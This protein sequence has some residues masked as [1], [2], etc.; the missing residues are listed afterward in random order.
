MPQLQIWDSSTIFVYAPIF[1]GINVIYLR[2]LYSPWSPRQFLSILIIFPLMLGTKHASETILIDKEI[3]LVYKFDESV[4]GL[5]FFIEN[6]APSENRSCFLTTSSDMLSPGICQRGLLHWVDIGSKMLNVTAPD[7]SIVESA[8]G[9]NPYSHLCAHAREFS[10][11]SF[12]RE[13]LKL[14]GDLKKDAL[15][16]IPF[17]FNAL[18]ASPW[19]ENDPEGTACGEAMER[20]ACDLYL[21]QCGRSCYKKTICRQDCLDIHKVCP[22]AFFNA[23]LASY[24]TGYTFMHLWAPSGLKEKVEPFTDLMRLMSNA[25][26]SSE[27][28][29]DQ[30]FEPTRTWE[31][32]GGT[33]D[34]CF[35]SETEP[36]YYLELSPIQSKYW[37]IPGIDA[38]AYADPSTHVRERVWPNTTVVPRGGDS[39]INAFP[40][41]RSPIWW[42][43]AADSVGAGLSSRQL[44]IL[45]QFF[46]F[47]FTSVEQHFN[48]FALQLFELREAKEIFLRVTNYYFVN[49]RIIMTLLAALIPYFISRR[50]SSAQDGVNENKE[51][52]DMKVNFNVNTYFVHFLCLCQCLIVTFM[53][54]TSAVLS[55]WRDLLSESQI[56]KNQTNSTVLVH[57]VWV[58][59]LLLYNQICSAII[60]RPAHLSKILD[61]A[62]SSAEDENSQ[63]Y[64]PEDEIKEE[65]IAVSYH[66]D[67]EVWWIT[68]QA[69][70]FYLRA[71][72]KA[73]TLLG[74][75]SLMLLPIY[76]YIRIDKLS[77]F[78]SIISWMM[79]LL[80][81]LALYWLLDSDAITFK[82]VKVENRFLI[83]SKIVIYP[84]IL[85]LVF[86]TNLLDKEVDKNRRKRN[87]IRFTIYTTLVHT[88]YTI[89][90]AH[91]VDP[92]HGKDLIGYK[93]EGTDRLPENR[94]PYTL[95]ITLLSFAA[96]IFRFGLLIDS[97]ILAIQKTRGRTYQ[98]IMQRPEQI[99][100]DDLSFWF[101]RT[102]PAKVVAVTADDE[103]SGSPDR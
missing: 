21:P 101:T 80:H 16:K 33:L 87:T 54:Y 36:S 59:S 60:L 65:E 1:I 35:D 27:L 48:F 49:M 77:L 51:L 57:A 70:S 76:E 45:L 47:R 25:S 97:F 81:A 4:E 22:P 12:S 2:S 64:E 31:E 5:S 10:Y 85:V 82:G 83:L 40:N 66:K 3:V 72:R 6:M 92:F 42:R 89:I 58:M 91:F 29:P 100:D 52:R 90:L 19:L 17:L 46:K 50:K 102:R 8:C 79:D 73:T 99:V 68:V 69:F 93:K 98:E 53:I 13:L 18:G 32:Q 30:C 7:V 62:V 103:T 43:S 88:V 61:M 78:R 67:E 38:E 86:G 14:V 37:D 20:M 34:S 44:E 56:N 26:C 95:L 24:T 74:A 55:E 94:I 75:V 28:I 11:Y 84:L 63:D 41:T 9:E 96:M 15:D 23:A 71:K 39:Q